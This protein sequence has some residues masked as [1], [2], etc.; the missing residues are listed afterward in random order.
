MRLLI[1]LSALAMVSCAKAPGFDADEKLVDEKGFIA[2]WKESRKAP[3]AASPGAETPPEESVSRVGIARGEGARSLFPDRLADARQLPLENLRLNEVPLRVFVK[4]LA[5]MSGYNIVVAPSVNPLLSIDLTAIDWR[6]ALYLIADIHNFDIVQNGR[7][8]YIK[9]SDAPRPNAA[10]EALA[11]DI[12]LFRLRYAEPDTVKE[13]LAPLLQT[14]AEQS[15]GAVIT[16]DERTRSIIVKG[17]RNQIA[18]AESLIRNV[19]IRTHQIMIEAFIVEAG[20][21]FE[22]NLGAR[23]GRAP[24]GVI[25]PTRGA[26]VNLPETVFSGSLGVL[27][28]HGRGRFKLELTALENEGKS[29]I[30]SN[31]RIFTLDNQQAVIFQGD[32]VP[33]QTVS[34]R[35]TR[36]QFKQAGLR[37][38]VTPSVVDEGR[39]MLAV[40]IN[41]DTVDTRISNPPITRRE[42]TS[43]LL[44]NDG[45]IVVIGGIRLD[46]SIN[47][48]GSVP[49]VSSIPVFGRILSRR[50]HERDVRELLVF[51]SPKIIL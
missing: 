35:G 24:D 37:L 41:K 28:G 14:G 39:L 32:E 21:D 12:E 25:D 15:A 30:I 4:T 47:S 8:I 36:T 26:Y 19:D 29:R 16:V 46:S 13:L 5:L 43:H 51:I 22:R 6:D 40:S 3:A 10:N 50:Q 48:V 1:I 31:P 9:G 45:D 49:L 17:G 42:L 34:D 38:Q 18:L 44:V 11:S 7:L 20:D 27:F 23:L 2:D 33:Y